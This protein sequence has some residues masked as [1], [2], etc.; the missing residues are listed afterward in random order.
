MRN[1]AFKKVLNSLEPNSEVELLAPIQMFA[2]PKKQQ[3]LVFLC[4]GIGVAAARPMI[5]EA[6]NQNWQSP[7][8]LFNSN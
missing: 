2:L 3:A 4:G 1:S 8:Y 5:I 6:L 7:I